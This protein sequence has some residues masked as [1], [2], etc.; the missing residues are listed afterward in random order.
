MGPHAPPRLGPAPAAEPIWSFYLFALVLSW[1]VN[2][3]WLLRELR[4]VASGSSLLGL[5]T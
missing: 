4:R 5:R 3:A 2:L 1:L